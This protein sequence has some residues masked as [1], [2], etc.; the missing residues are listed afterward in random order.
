MTQIRG[1]VLAGGKSSRMG[2]DKALLPVNQRFAIERQC[3]LL[4]PF[5]DQGVFIAGSVSAELDQQRWPVVKDDVSHQGPLSGILSAIRHAQQGIA[6][7]IAVDLLTLTHGDIALLLD[8]VSLNETPTHDV[9]FAQSHSDQSD[10]GVQPLCAI[11]SVES[12][13]P[14]LS[15]QFEAKQRSVVKAWLDLKRQPVV[16]HDSHLTNV[17]SPTDF[18]KFQQS[19][20]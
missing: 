18:E 4:Q 17:N 1:Y 10:H 20:G 7:I 19:K 13:L 3:E 12:C 6:I 9:Y 5:C 2:T 8:Q 16:I 14:V 15:H 11:W